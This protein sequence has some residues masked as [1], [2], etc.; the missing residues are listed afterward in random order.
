MGIVNIKI[1]PK[2]ERVFFS[3]MRSFAKSFCPNFELSNFSVVLVFFSVFAVPATLTPA[4]FPPNT[5]YHVV[6]S[7]LFEL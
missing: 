5:R 2:R 4:L 7:R 6:V 3:L 1:T